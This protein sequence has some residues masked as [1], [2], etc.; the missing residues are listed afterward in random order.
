M[1]DH[2]V[3]A[4]AEFPVPARDAGAFC[5]MKRQPVSG[6]GPVAVGTDAAAT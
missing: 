5:R 1:N 3:L 4:D 6:P 2:A